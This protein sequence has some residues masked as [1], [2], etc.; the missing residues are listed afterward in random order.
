M[1]ITYPLSLPTVKGF[2]RVVVLP[3]SVV[4]V[5]VSPFTG[6][7]QVQPHPG[8]WWGLD[9]EIPPMKRADAEEWIAFLLSLNGPEGT[10]LAG[11]P[12]GGT[13]RGVATGTPQVAGASQTGR[14]L[15][16]DGWTISITN[17]LRAGDWIQMGTGA[18]TRWHK[19]MKDVNS[20]GGGNATLD[21]WPALRESPADNETIIT[22][23]TVGLFR[24]A[25]NEMPYT[26]EQAQMYGLNFSAVEAL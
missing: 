25:S 11:D 10:F 24:L 8:Q 16:T 9:L 26:L 6:E 15:V 19:N 22:A 14:V 4:G 23:N 12:L 20:D 1:A 2:A 13:P 17:I 7:Q 5:S 18:S 3:R 21:L